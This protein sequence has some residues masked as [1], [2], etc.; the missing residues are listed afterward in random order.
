[1]IRRFLAFWWDFVVGDDWRG[2]A[3]VTAGLLLTAGASHVASTSWVIL[4][5][6]A[7][8]SVGI[9]LRRAVLRYESDGTA[10]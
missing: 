1:M 10:G 3:G 8:L 2:A 5:V 7:G 4:P 9:S 6:A